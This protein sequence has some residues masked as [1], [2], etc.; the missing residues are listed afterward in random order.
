MLQSTPD[1]F[2][3]LPHLFKKAIYHA[4]FRKIETYNMMRA[5]IPKTKNNC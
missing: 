3:L 2:S 4:L 5:L 1:L